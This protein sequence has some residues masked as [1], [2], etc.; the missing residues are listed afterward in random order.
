MVEHSAVAYIRT[1]LTTPQPRGQMLESSIEFNLVEHWFIPKTRET[2]IS[3]VKQPSHILQHFNSNL[4]I[5]TTTTTILFFFY[6]SASTLN[7]TD[8]VRP[9]GGEKT[10]R[11][12]RLP[13]P[14]YM[15]SK[16]LNERAQRPWAN[17]QK[18]K[19]RAEHCFNLSH[20]C[21]FQ[22]MSKSKK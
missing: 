8:T 4:A 16:T 6:L 14:K 22:I 1:Q 13:P 12:S 10:L 5:T 9:G 20:T 2:S 7:N 17:Q 11:S 19:Q 3:T 18:R 21:T 15:L